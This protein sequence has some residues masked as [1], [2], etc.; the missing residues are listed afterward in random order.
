MAFSIMIII[1]VAGI[2]LSLR[3]DAL[4]LMTV[5]II[6]GFST[7]IMA[8][9]GENNQI[10][11]LSYL[12][13][14]DAAILTVAIFK[15]WHSVNAIGFVSTVILFFSWWEKFY[16]QNDLGTTMLFLIFFFII[17]SISSLIYNIVKREKSTGVE[18]IL[19]LASAFVFFGASYGLLNDGYHEI[20]GFFALALAIYYFL[21]AFFMRNV[22]PED[23]NLYNFL[24]FLTIGFVTLAIP[25]QFEKNIITISWIIEAALI[26]AIGTK[27]KKVPTILFSVIVGALALFRYF[28]FDIEKY[29]QNTLLVFNDIFLTAI[30]IIVVLYVI[31]YIIQVFLDEELPG[32]KKSSMI[33]MFAVAANFITIFSVSYEITESYG[34]DINAVRIV[35]EKAQASVS[36]VSSKSITKYNSEDYYSS[37]EYKLNQEKIN[38]LENRSSITLS[39]FWLIYSILLLA[40]GII[41][42]NKEV[43]LGGIALLLLAIFKLFFIDL[44]SLGTLYRIISS[45]SLGVVLLSISFVYQ[46]YKD[47]IKDII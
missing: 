20:M 17:F 46:K 41:S 28:L 34:R 1:T 8:S 40:I 9:T 36:N 42:K 45:M 10:G 27:L 47:K 13:L 26:M 33:I 19:T 12:I 18:Q 3:Y 38:K 15:K 43:R 30:I 14:L 25:I 2:A 21:W 7:P 35:Q 16:T 39:I 6:G 22:M 44:W 37:S 4:A 23:E 31:T 11:L 24:A 32:I 5:A 29:D